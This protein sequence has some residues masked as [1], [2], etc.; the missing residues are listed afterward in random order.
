MGRC[1]DAGPLDVHP[2]V[3]PPALATGAAT[4]RRLFH[5]LCIGHFPTHA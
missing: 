2:T 5:D 1:P 3:L 4:D